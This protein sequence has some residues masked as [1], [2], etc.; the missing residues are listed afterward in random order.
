[1]K[2]KSRAKIDSS[3]WFAYA[4]AGVASS[5]VST[6]CAEGAIHY[7]GLIN[8]RFRGSDEQ[9]FPLVPG[10]S[11]YFKHIHSCFGM[12]CSFPGE[13]VVAIR[14]G[15]I[16]GYIPSCRYFQ[17]DVSASNLDAHATLTQLPFSAKPGVL[18]AGATT[19]SCGGRPFRGEFRYDSDGYVGFRFDVG[20]GVQYGWAR[21]SVRAL[22]SAN[23][24]LVDYAYADPGE[25][26]LAGQKTE[27]DAGPVQEESLGVLALGATGVLAWRR[28]RDVCSQRREW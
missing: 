7:S 26:I 11:L 19:S 28:R 13:A 16:A 8:Q 14:G 27:R 4:V 12:Y 6:P 23:F 25:T 15:S 3:R 1:M 24:R 10:A 17:G 5:L 21:V 18:V 22:V 2:S 20:N 9:T